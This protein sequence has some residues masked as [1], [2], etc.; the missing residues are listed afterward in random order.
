MDSST[1]FQ[2]V[3]QDFC[4]VVGIDDWH[5]I[6]ELGYVTV[7]NTVVELHDQ[8]GDY[9]DPI[10]GIAI[11]FDYIDIPELHRQLLK[12]NANSS[13][14]S[15]GYFGLHPTTSVV[16]YFSSAILTSEQKG[17]QLA[18]NICQFIQVGRDKLH[19]ALRNTLPQ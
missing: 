15:L 10:I 4:S 17:K 19:N 18:N 8:T 11:H 16:T 6:L 9:S 5:S 3:I 1:L 7:D 13:T 12:I 14:Y 2:Y